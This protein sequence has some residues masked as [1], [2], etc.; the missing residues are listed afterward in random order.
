MGAPRQ[1]THLGGDAAYSMVP[2][3]GD[4]NVGISI[5]GDILHAIERKQ[6]KGVRDRRRVSATELTGGIN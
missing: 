3:V 5:D 4:I 6:N 2:G 1:R